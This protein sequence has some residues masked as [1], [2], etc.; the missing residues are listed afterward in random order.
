MHLSEG[1]LP[2]AQAL[3]WSVASAP[4]AVHSARRLQQDPSRR[5]LLGVATALAFA[6]TLFPIPVPGLG[7]TSHMCATPFLALILGPA[8][9]ALPMTLALALQAL[10]FAHGGLSTLGANVFTLGIAGP[11][12]AWSL[13][14]LLRAAG[15]GPR[16]AAGLACGLGAAGVYV[17]DALMLGLALRGTQPF[18]HWVKVALLGFAPVQAPLLLLEGILSALLIAA[19]AARREDLVPAWLRPVANRTL[20]AALGLLL[21]LLPLQVRAAE[22]MKGL[23]EKVMEKA[24]E[25][26]GR[27]PKPLLDLTEG[28]TGLA[29]FMAGGLG[30]GFI[31]GRHWERLKTRPKG[32]EA[33]RDAQA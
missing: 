18:G 14:R 9:L 10:L 4:F 20:P 30:A 24:A 21:L 27:H 25:D 28:E 8:A 13:A 15:V 33:I 7:A 32:T 29:L 1:I 12:L 23:D 19:L 22:P 2:A 11:W 26:A 16:L 3:A 6:V 5:G 17:L 31:L